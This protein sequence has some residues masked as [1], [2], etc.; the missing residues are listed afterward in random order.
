MQSPATSPCRKAPSGLHQGSGC[1][2]VHFS[3]QG[4]QCA[5]LPTL[6]TLHECIINSQSFF[7]H[8]IPWIILQF[9]LLV[10]PHSSIYCIQLCVCPSAPTLCRSNFLMYTSSMSY[11]SSRSHF[12]I[13]SFSQA[14]HRNLETSLTICSA[15]TSLFDLPAILVKYAWRNMREGFSFTR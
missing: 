9:L 14:N 6:F 2:Y 8:H 11:S 7:V 10:V 3:S 4:G 15:C 12:G 13:G 1:A 5:A